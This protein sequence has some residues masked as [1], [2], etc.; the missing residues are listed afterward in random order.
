MGGAYVKYGGGGSLMC[1]YR[2]LVGT[3]EGKRLFENLK[4]ELM[5]TLEWIL[6][7]SVR[8]ASTRLI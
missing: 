2:I 6:Q 8:K 3:L 1:T 4:V 5:V 7:K